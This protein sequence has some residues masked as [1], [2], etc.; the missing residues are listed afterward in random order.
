MVDQISFL[1][2]VTILLYILFAFCF[3]CSGHHVMGLKIEGLGLGVPTAFFDH[4][5]I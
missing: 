2:F 5:R 3:V 1:W 4:S